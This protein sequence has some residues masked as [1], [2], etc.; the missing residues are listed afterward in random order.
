MQKNSNDNAIFFIKT[1]LNQKIIV[2]SAIISSLYS[3][4]EYFGRNG[5]VVYCFSLL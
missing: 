1:L 5:C 3:Q 2:F 4:I